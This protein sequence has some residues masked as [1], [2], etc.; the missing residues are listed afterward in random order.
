MIRQTYQI[1]PSRYTDDQRILEFHSTKDKP[2]HIKPRGVVVDG[3]CPWWLS[4]C[5]NRIYRLFISSDL[6]DQRI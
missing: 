5:K 4:P 1:I 3:T 6:A 2:D